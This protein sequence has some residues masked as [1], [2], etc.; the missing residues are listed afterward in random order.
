MALATASCG[1]DSDILAIEIVDFPIKNCDFPIKNGDLPIKN[2]DCP[3]RYV[4]SLCLS[5]SFV[6]EDTHRWRTQP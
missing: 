5:Q 2:G 6:G 4:S 3:V 1:G